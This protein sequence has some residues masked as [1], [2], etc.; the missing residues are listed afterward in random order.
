MD[1][2]IKTLSDDPGDIHAI[3]LDMTTLSEHERAWL[4]S[5][6]FEEMWDDTFDHAEYILLFGVD[7]IHPD[8]G[9]LLERIAEIEH[10]QWMDWSQSVAAD[11]DISD[12]RRER[13]EGYW[14]PYD[15]L[16]EDV[17]EADRDYARKVLDEIGADAPEPEP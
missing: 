12:E 1:V 13:W 2:G 3:C 4:Y 6:S 17:K 7:S 16:P 14:V 15:E 5:D 10:E 8:D 11:E 9:S